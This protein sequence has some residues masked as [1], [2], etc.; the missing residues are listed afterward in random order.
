M[1]SGALLFFSHGQVSAARMTGGGVKLFWALA[2][3]GLE[4]QSPWLLLWDFVA[5]TLGM[6]LHFCQL[7]VTLPHCSLARQC[8]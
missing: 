8:P 3:S 4:S 6:A 5:G 2:I 7:P 1:Y